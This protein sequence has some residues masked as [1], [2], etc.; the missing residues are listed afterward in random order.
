V[1][2]ERAEDVSVGHSIVEEW[3]KVL[4]FRLDCLRGGNGLGRL[5]G[6]G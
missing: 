1:E 2:E 6:C 5:L 3:V 4:I